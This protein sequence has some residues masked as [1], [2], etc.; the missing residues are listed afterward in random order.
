MMDRMKGELVASSLYARFIDTLPRTLSRGRVRWKAAAASA[1]CRATLMS[2]T[3]GRSKSIA[4][5][6]G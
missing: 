6:C 5:S 2:V 1:N 3:R 4:A